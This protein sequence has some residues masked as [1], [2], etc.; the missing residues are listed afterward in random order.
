MA[1]AT[2]GNTNGAC[3]PP[4]DTTTGISQSYIYVLE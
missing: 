4:K 3:S 1:G 2:L